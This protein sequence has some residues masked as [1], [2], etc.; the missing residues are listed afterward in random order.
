MDNRPI[1][2]IR[3]DLTENYRALAVEE[4]KIRSGKAT[5][6]DVENANKLAQ[7]T[8]RLQKHVEQFDAISGV[9]ERGRQIKD[10]PLPGDRRSERD[11]IITTPGHKF[12]HSEAFAAYSAMGKQ[13]WSGKVDV[14]SFEPRIE[15]RGEDADNFLARMETKDFDGDLPTY[16]GTDTVLKPFDRD[17]DVIRIQEPQILTVRDVMTVLPTRS[18]TIRFTRYEYTQSAKSQDG[19]GAVKPYA[20][21]VVTAANQPVETIAVLH[22][23][24][25]Q[26]IDDAP[27]LIGIING[28]MRLDVRQEEERQ[29]IWAEGNDGEIEGLFEQGVEDYEID[30]GRIEG[31]DTLIDKIRRMRTDL[32]KRRVTPNAVLIDPLDWEN[33]ELAKG[34]ATGNDHY[35]WGLV[36]TLRGPMIW[37]MTVVESDALEAADG[38]RRLVMG[39]FIRGATLYDRHDVRL[40]VGFVDDDFA[41]NLRTLKAEERVA[42]GVKRPWA[43]SWLETAEATS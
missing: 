11:S 17:P 23:V 10:Q 40:A 4:A 35:I 21:T 1:K 12:V 18:D 19:R 42:L 31:T 24:S 26:D 36:S 33:I 38:S 6:A 37:S 7:E 32:R 22:K 28:E 13:G 2:E 34:A 5:S 43:F 30:A 20:A 15:L 9:A 8:E 39:D 3:R 27:R 41:R 16:T 14:K 25:E 29:L